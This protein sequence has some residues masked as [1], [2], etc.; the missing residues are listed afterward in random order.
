[1][2]RRH[3]VAALLCTA[4]FT[5]GCSDIGS[6]SLL[7]S[8][9]SAVIRGTSTDGESTEVMAVLRAGGMASTTY[10]KLE[11]DDVLTVQVGDLTQP[12]QE[13]SLGA[14][15]SYRTTMAVA[16]PELP[17][18]VSLDRT[19]DEGAPNTTFSLPESFQ[20]TTQADQI[21]PSEA[22]QIAWE[23]SGTSDQLRLEVSGECIDGGIQDL[24][25][26]DGVTTVPSDYLDSV[27]EQPGASCPVEVTISKIRSGT[28]DPAYGEGGLAQG[29][30]SRS[31]SFTF[32]RE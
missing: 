12:L 6:S 15:T 23:P 8:G 27:V 4:V 16:D 11:D 20:I 3:L 2:T 7:T 25:G 26:D 13:V 14:L 9:M 18:S 19:L 1:M 5:V 32:S 31:V 21:D 28:L 22:I 24:T 30:Q 17:F 29:V 10:V